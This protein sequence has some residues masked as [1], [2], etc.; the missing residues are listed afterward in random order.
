MAVTLSAGVLDRYDQFM[1]Y[2]SPYVAH[3]RGRAV[4]LYPGDPT[5][6]APGEG[7]AGLAAKTAD[8]ESLGVL[9]GGLPHYDGGGL[10]R[11][12]PVGERAGPTAES[13]HA[14]PRSGGDGPGQGS[15]ERPVYLAGGRV[16]RAEGR[17]VTWDDVTATANGDPVRGLA[18][19]PSRSDA[20]VRLVGERVDLPVGTDVRVAIRHG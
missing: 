15:R 8:G 7:F 17:D 4:D 10:L 5:H 12:S 20:G 19:V 16:G 11:R 14:R 18:L 6:P 9:D 3:D 2:N 1:L 13:D